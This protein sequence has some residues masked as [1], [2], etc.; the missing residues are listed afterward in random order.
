MIPNYVEYNLFVATR[1]WEDGCAF[2]IFTVYFTTRPR[3]KSWSLVKI[4]KDM[5]LLAKY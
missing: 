3:K 4:I 1:S 5:K 2:P